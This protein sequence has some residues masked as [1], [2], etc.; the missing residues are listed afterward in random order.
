M[1]RCKECNTGFTQLDKLASVDGR[2]MSCYLI[3]NTPKP[4]SE[5]PRVEARQTRWHYTKIYQEAR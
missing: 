4:I 2:C 5:R 3:E 1:D